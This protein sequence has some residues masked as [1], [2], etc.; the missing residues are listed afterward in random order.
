MLFRSIN[1]RRGGGGRP[2]IRGAF[3]S[4]RPSTVG[5][6]DRVSWPQVELF[7]SWLLVVG[8]FELFMALGREI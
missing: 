7:D 4:E 6:F 2:G 8:P 1:V 5:K 3:D